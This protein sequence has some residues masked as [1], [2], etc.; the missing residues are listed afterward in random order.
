M[1]PFQSDRYYIPNRGGCL[2]HVRQCL[3]SAL[4]LRELL[5]RDMA[6]SSKTIGC[7]GK[8]TSGLSLKEL[9]WIT[10]NIQR[11]LADEQGRKIFRK[12]LSR[13]RRKTDL[14][15][16]DLYEQVAEYIDNECIHRL[17]TKSPSVEPLLADFNLALSAAKDL[18]DV[19]EID[20]TL[21]ERYVQA[22][23][24]RSRE[25]MLDVLEETR[26]K[27]M[28][29]LRQ[30]HKGFQAYAKMPCPQSK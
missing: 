23:D 26:F 21:L 28:N 9:D 24:S 13:G 18:D 14:A 11:T 8:C 29:H 12:Y 30:A 16:L 2:Y 7:I 22:A 1:H 25:S 3:Q 19:S 20:L 6:G 4:Q 10:D 15:C 27:M 17:S 5:Q